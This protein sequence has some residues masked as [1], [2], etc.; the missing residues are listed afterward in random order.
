MKLIARLAA[1]LTLV[2]SS[3]VAFAAEQTATLEV[4]N[5][6]CESCAPIVKR[7]LSRV[8]GVSQVTVTEG[9]SDI[10]TATVKFD[11]AKTNVTALVAA[12]TKAGYPSRAVQ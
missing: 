11:D 7:S 1:A 9:S 3:G 5:V 8:P 12:T 4:K 2:L 10:A 6:G